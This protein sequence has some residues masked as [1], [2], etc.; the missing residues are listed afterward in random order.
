MSKSAQL[1]KHGRYR[2]WSQFTAYP[3]PEAV[4][5]AGPFATLDTAQQLRNDDRF[6]KEFQ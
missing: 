5:G 4:V 6:G 2:F 1:F 3:S